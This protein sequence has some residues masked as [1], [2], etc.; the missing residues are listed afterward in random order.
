MTRAYLRE[1]SQVRWFIDP[2]MNDET[3][4]SVFER[5]YHQ[6]KG[7]ALAREGW[8][9]EFCRP[10]PAAGLPM[11][12]R[13]IMRVA[14]ALG[15]RPTRLLRTIVPDRPDMLAP[16]HRRAFCRACWVEDDRADRPRY[17]RR[18]WAKALCLRC[19]IHG[20]PL[21]VAPRPQYPVTDIPLPLDGPIFAAQERAVINMTDC[22][23]DQLHASLFDAAAWPAQWHLDA[24]RARNLLGRCV[25]NLLLDPA[26]C[27]AHWVWL[28]GQNDPVCQF[29]TRPAASTRGS[30]WEAFRQLD[31]PASRRAALWMVA[32]VVMPGL[33]SE[34]RPQGIKEH[35]F[36]QDP[37]H[38]AREETRSAGRRMMRIRTALAREGLAWMA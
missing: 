38:M 13:N 29:R 9:V 6:Y 12:S 37:A 24:L 17:F 35:L 7:I 31:S 4:D 18:S 21:R 36:G 2:P 27:P 1:S 32:W 33:P 20:E 19:A 26:P 23:A 22:F 25:S 3:I 5:A 14:R 30:I 16:G 11:T 15:V 8:L 10:Q 34:L 28:G